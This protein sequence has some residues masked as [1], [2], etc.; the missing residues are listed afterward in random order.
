V[1]VIP[2]EGAPEEPVEELRM[3]MHAIPRAEVER[4]LGESGVRVLDVAQD[5]A[6]GP[7]WV[8]LRYTATRPPA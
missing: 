2:T 4:I 1:H 6:A 7:G 5:D 8:S 3:E